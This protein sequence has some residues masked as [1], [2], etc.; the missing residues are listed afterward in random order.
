MIDHYF[1]RNRP[2]SSFLRGCY[3]GLLVPPVTG[4]LPEDQLDLIVTQRP[5]LHKDPGGSWNSKETYGQTEEIPGKCLENIM[6]VD[7]STTGNEDQV[8]SQ[9]FRCSELPL[10]KIQLSNFWAGNI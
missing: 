5:A 6:F 4:Y 7:K 2:S 9:N 10:W 1:H 8:F 3:T